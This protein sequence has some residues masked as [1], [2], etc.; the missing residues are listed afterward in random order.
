MSMYTEKTWPQQ[1]LQN[2]YKTDIK[3]EQNMVKEI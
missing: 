1:Q 2:N 3:Y